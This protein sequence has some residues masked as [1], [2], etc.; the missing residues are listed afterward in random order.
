MRAP[1]L[2]ARMQDCRALGWCS[3]G[4]RRWL[5]RHGVPM[6]RFLAEGVPVP[7]LREQ[8]DAFAEALA[9]H[10]EQRYGRW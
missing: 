6:E 9:D 10:V 7:W 4:V 5:A 8:R 2:M 3:A 1:P